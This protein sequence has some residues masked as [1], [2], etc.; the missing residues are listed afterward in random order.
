MSDTLTD[1]LTDVTCHLSLRGGGTLY[2]CGVSERVSCRCS[3][4]QPQRRYAMAPSVENVWWQCRTYGE[5]EFC[6]D[7][8]EDILQD[9]KVL[10]KQIDFLPYSCPLL[11]Y[12][13]VQY[14]TVQY[15]EL[16]QISVTH[17]IP[18]L[19]SMPSNSILSYPI[20]LFTSLQ[21]FTLFHSIRS[22]L[23]VSTLLACRRHVQ[24]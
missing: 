23:T 7:A 17:P 4:R 5:E 2:G 18:S 15:S 21:H 19:S 10:R 13:A 22:H 11:H 20:S 3:C 1:A 6:R 14:N 16:H 12:N 8:V 9:F 24:E